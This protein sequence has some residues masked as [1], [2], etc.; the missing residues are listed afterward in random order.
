VKDLI[1]WDWLVYPM[2]VNN[3]GRVH[4]RG[5]EAEAGYNLANELFASINYTYTNPVDETTGAKLYTIPESVIKGILTY[6][7]EKSVYVPFR[8]GRHNYAV[9]SGP[10]AV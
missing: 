9:P 4:I 7:P 1:Q 10:A 8:A 6:Y 3:I 2:Q 5:Y